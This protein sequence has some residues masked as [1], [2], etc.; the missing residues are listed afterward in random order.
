MPEL[1][2]VETIRSDLSKEILGKKLDSIKISK[3]KIVKSSIVNFRKTLKDSH[4]KKINR[5]G[6]LLVFVLNKTDKFLLIHLKMTGQLI[7][8]SKKNV[9][10]GGHNYPEI[11]KLPNKFSHIIFTFSNKSKLFYNDVRQ[12]GYMKIVS[13]KELGEILLRF[14]MDPIASKFKKSDFFEVIK[15]K[16]TNIKAFLL[17]QKYIAGIGNIYAD[18]ILFDSRVR[19]IRNI[20][21]LSKV[22]KEKI[23]LAIK[24]IIKKAIKMRGTTFSNYVDGKGEKGNFTKLLKVY[25]REDKK[26]F[27]CRKKIKRIRIAG[28]GTHYCSNCQR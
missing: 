8:S 9:I 5:I 22:E 10:S 21:S 14:G 1:P 28:R 7:Y 16:K 15:G 11:D 17:N 24:K 18:E 20:S 27:K 19:P 6:K 23:Y 2:E 25:Q 3:P 12:F 4:F 13:Q 26:C